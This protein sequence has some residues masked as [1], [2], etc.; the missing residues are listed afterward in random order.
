MFCFK[1]IDYPA[2]Q[3]HFPAP[4]QDSITAVK[5]FL[6]DKILTKYGVDPI[7]IGIL[8]DSSGG[9]LAVAVTQ[10][11]HLCLLL[12]SGVQSSFFPPCR[13]PVPPAV[14]TEKTIL[15]H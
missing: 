13:H 12:G 11:V 14:F 6:Q 2:P 5:F 9:T 3:H 1:A 10:Q 8:G 4:F 15:S 7:Q